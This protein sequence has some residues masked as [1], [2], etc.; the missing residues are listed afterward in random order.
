MPADTLQDQ[1]EG[2]WIP[3]SSCCSFWLRCMG[4]FSFNDLEIETVGARYVTEDAGS[5]AAIR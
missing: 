5:E 1:I 2:I 3:S 4:D